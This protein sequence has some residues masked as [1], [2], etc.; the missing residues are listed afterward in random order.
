VSDRRRIEIGMDV[1]R[2]IERARLALDESEDE[3]L[4][5]LLIP[6]AGRAA[7]P[8]GRR[9]A[10]GS[11]RSRGLWSVEIA[12]RRIAAPNLKQAYRTLLCEL[13]RAH[14]HFLDSF[15]AEKGRTR[16]YVARTPDTLYPQAPHLARHAAP[17]VDGWYY[18]SNLSTARAGHLARVAARLCGLHYGSDVRIL[19]N[20]RE[21]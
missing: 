9:I 20:L 13:A 10:P 16:R 21:L 2:A 18:D 14:P 8:A 3:I 15:A 11:V 6:P 5:R 7:G 4:R 12:G 17:L 1:H 19:D